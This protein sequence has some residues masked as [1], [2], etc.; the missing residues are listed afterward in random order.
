MATTLSALDLPFDE[1]IAFLR[2][3]ANVTS[4]DYTDVWG[5]ANAKSFTV[6]GAGTQALVDDFR[7]EVAKALETG[8]SLQEFRK[9]FDAIV[10]K[11]GWDHTGTPGWR[12]RIIFETNLGM[13][14]SAGRYA[15]QTETETLAA[16]PFWQYVHSGALH[17]R[18]QHQ[19]W[20]G[21]TLRADDP[22]WKTHYPPNGWRCG[23]RTRPVSARGLARMGKSGPDTAPLIE[24]KEYT[25]RKTGEVMRVPDG[26][27]PGFDYNVGEEWTGHAPQ[28]P[29]NATLTAKTATPPSTSTPPAPAAPVAPPPLPAP[30]PG[31]VLVVPPA[32]AV[33]GT[34]IPKPPAWVG[35]LKPEPAPAKPPAAPGIAAPKPPA[36]AP[37]AVN[38]AT[39][40]DLRAADT[41]LH[42]DFIGWGKGLSVVES[43]ALEAYKGSAYRGMNE[44][45]RGKRDATGTEPMIRAL[46]TAL[47]RA[48]TKRAV[49]VHRGVKKGTAWDSLQVGD[50]IHDPG[51]TSTSI[52]PQTAANFS[53]GVRIEMRLP[54]GYTGGAYVNRIP[55]LN[56][57]EFEF[58]IRPG[59]PFRVVERTGNRIVVEPVRGGRR[60][61][62]KLAR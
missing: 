8:T 17:P 7:S 60:R 28:I 54:K 23:C 46:D 3:K 25:N 31:P 12:S 62:P 14:Y 47:S 19:A 1:A 53:G 36:A 40:A 4:R 10:T 16:F 27:D 11:H 37:A 22:W 42:A 13:A 30:D 51:F 33:S 32:P 5:K 2:Q 50:K 52:N 21:T 26:I 39:D 49:T 43:D 59:A 15:Q 56:H 34:P 41:L 18:K 20:N 55:D 61:S 48:K 58:L 29:A 9:T 45:L 57:Q 44:Y 38:V 24:M 6:A 35:K